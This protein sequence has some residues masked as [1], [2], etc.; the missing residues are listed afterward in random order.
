MYLDKIALFIVA[1]LLVF[2]VLSFIVKQ[3]RKSE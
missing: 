3:F 2:W 1:G